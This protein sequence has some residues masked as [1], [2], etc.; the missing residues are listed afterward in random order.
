MIQQI[1]LSGILLSV[2]AG[3][4][5]LLIRRWLSAIYAKWWILCLLLLSA[6]IPAIFPHLSPYSTPEIDYYAYDGWN[7]VDIEDTELQ[8]CYKAAADSKEFCRC[9]V[10]Q[11]SKIVLYKP[12]P[13]YDFLL[14]CRQPALWVL[15]IVLGLWLLD[16]LLK[17]A[18]LWHLAR[19]SPKVRYQINGTTFYL[20]YPSHRYFPL[21]AF[22]LWRHY[23]VWS[24]VLEQFNEQERQLIFL[25]ELGHLRQRDTWAHLFWR[26]LGLL[27]W[28]LP[29]Y[30][31]L[32]REL[33]QLNEFVADEFALHHAN[34]KQY[35]HLLIRAKEYQ[36][37]QTGKMPAFAFSFAQSILKKR[38]LHILDY[39]NKKQ[40]SAK[41][42]RR[43]L[44]YLL[45]IAFSFWGICAW[46]YPVFSKQSADLQEYETLRTENIETGKTAFCKDCLIQQPAEDK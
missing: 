26:G 21:S 2:G 6:A 32:R 43:W 19:T 35:A 40:Q 45:C 13:W 12:S 9:E 8:A 16:T 24:P 31:W 34:A 11:K 33:N 14:H 25:H 29:T 30:Y 20:L 37:Q 3:F 18:F 15:Y 4:Y 22:T 27:W 44:A 17:W 10:V 28:M 46:L 23:I 38:V 39:H 5:F 42:P 1:L 36:L 41:Q 7:Q